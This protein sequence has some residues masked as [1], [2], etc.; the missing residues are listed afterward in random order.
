MGTDAGRTLSTELGGIPWW[1][2]YCAPPD[3]K[4]P[5]IDVCTVSAERAKKREK[6]KERKAALRDTS[7]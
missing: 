1:R 3:I 2:R 6:E 4:M 5:V 7:E